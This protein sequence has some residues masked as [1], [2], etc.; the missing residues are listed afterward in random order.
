MK[1]LT[2]ILTIGLLFFSTLLHAAWLKN[3]PQT[4]TQPDGTVINCLATGDEFY[5]WLHDNEGFTIIQ[6]HTTG[7]YTYAQLEEG[8]LVPSKFVV[9]KSD[10]TQAIGPKNS[11]LEKLSQIL[12]KRIRIV[13]QPTEKNQEAMETFVKTITSP[14]EYNAFELKNNEVKITAG[15][16]G[17]ARLI[18]RG[19]IRQKELS[20]ILEQYFGVK[21]L[22]IA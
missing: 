10:V 4:I 15:R 2:F 5:N 7:F 11:N 3:V 9:G 17:K 6:D 20:E 1:K 19:R 21:K 22:N 13:A 12:K 18:G 16:E 14:I 8:K